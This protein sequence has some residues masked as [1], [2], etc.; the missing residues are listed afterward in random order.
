MHKGFMR[1][2]EK[3]EYKGKSGLVYRKFG[4]LISRECWGRTL[5]WDAKLKTAVAALTPQ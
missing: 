4:M 3:L 2:Q 1:N 5:L